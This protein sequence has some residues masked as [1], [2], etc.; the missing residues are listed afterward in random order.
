MKYEFQFEF[1][2]SFIYTALKRDVFW[3]AALFSGLL[4]GILFAS[5]LGIGSFEPLVVGVSI[6]AIA[7]ICV[8][9]HMALRSGSRRVYE[10]WS[11]QSPEHIIIWRL[12][13][14]GFK[15]DMVGSASGFEWKGLRRLWRYKDVWILEIVKNMSVFFPPDAAPKEVREYVVDR[16][17]EAGVR[18]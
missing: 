4:L 17:I 8:R 12:D 7:L 18:V 3:K 10:L 5:R 15:I 1:D 14:E 11:K 9:L 13:D 16:C 2:A 6:G